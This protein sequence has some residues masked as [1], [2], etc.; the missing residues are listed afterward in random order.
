[1]RTFLSAL[2]PEKVESPEMLCRVLKEIW[3]EEPIEVEDI[4]IEEE[5]EKKSAND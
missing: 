4:K 5:E 3:V 2:I 1:M